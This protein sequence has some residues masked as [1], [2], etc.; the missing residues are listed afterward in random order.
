MIPFLLMLKKRIIT[1]LYLPRRKIEMLCN[2]FEKLNL[3]LLKRQLVK[4]MINYVRLLL[5]L[6]AAPFCCLF[7]KMISAFMMKI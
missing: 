4:L 1:N 3:K 6:F 2:S 7:A 5:V